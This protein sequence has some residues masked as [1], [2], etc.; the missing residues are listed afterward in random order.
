MDTQKGPL[1]GFRVL[2]LG[3]LIAAPYAGLSGLP[4]ALIITAE[5]DPLRDEGEA[6]GERL[7]EAGVSVKVSR[8]E[9]MIHDF[10]DLFE[11]P[12]KQALAEIASVLQAAFG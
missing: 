3:N 9:G 12:G 8:Y 2:E 10:P 1:S 11:E 5:Y 6:Y 4:P 7:K